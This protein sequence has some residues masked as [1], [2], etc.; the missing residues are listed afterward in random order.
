MKK[1]YLG[2]FLSFSL[3]S[4]AQISHYWYLKVDDGEKFESVM[5]DYFL[6]VAQHAV[7]NGE[8]FTGWSVWRKTGEQK[9]TNTTI[10]LLLVAKALRTLH[11]L[12]IGIQ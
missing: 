4:N 5:K 12:G 11:R 8:T 10:L 3:L 6:K 2:L 9:L 1:L 7:D